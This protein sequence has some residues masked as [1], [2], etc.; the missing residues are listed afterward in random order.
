MSIEQYKKESNKK[1]RKDLIESVKKPAMKKVDDWLLENVVEPSHSY[2]ETAGKIGS[3]VAAMGSA[4]ADFATPDSEL[5]VAM[6]GMGP[7]VGLLKK[8]SKVLKKSI[9]SLDEVDHFLQEAPY[10]KKYKNRIKQ[11][12]K[13]SKYN[14]D[15]PEYMDQKRR[16]TT[17]EG[18][19]AATAKRT[20]DLKEEAVWDIE[21]TVE[22]DFPELFEELGD[23]FDSSPNRM[24]QEWSMYLDEYKDDHLD[25]I[26]VRGFIDHLSNYDIDP[27]EL[28]DAVDVAVKRLS[29][30]AKEAK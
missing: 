29:T 26:S 12:E 17:R 4:V 9:D 25:M 11:E 14:K 20:V 6:A 28:E 24:K 2:G 15:Y 22:D 1:P 27:Y 5:D 8:G 10:V 13:A 30:R 23:L 21:Q 16:N 3:G 19:G 7:L 18:F